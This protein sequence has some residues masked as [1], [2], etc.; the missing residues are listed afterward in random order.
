MFVCL[1]FVTKP[2][3]PYFASCFRLEVKPLI[4]YPLRSAL[5]EVLPKVYH[6]PEPLNG[7]SEVNT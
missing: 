6:C 7:P 5:P 2:E 4:V 1:F 3:N